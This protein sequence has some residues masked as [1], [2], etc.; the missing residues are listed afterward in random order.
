MEAIVVYPRLFQGWSMFAPS[1]PVDDGR[2]VVDGI[3]KDGRRWD[4]LNGGTP[5]F[6]LAPKRGFGMNQI[7]G[8]FERRAFEDRFKVYWNGI[9]EYLRN[10]HQ[11]T[12]RPQDEL[13]AFD[14]YWVS[15]WIPPPGG[16]QQKEPDRRKLFSFGDM[17]RATGKQSSTAPTPRS[18]GS[19]K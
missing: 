15:E 14:V 4:P 1:P 13:V 7:W 18:A 9:R 8:D 19:A 10:H 3:T 6:G 16:K 11:L 12:G 2:L 17:A 5:D